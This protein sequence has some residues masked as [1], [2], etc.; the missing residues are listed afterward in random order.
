[1]N[2]FLKRV[3]GLLRRKQLHRDLEDELRFHQE[4][5][6]EDVQGSARKQFGNPTS[7]EEAC[8]DLWAFIWIE[9]LWQDV[10]YAART[11][12]KRPGFTITVVLALALGIGANTTIYTVVRSALAFNI[13]VEHMERLVVITAVDAARRD[14]FS[15]SWTE[16]TDLRR[17][18][19]SIQ[20]LAAYRMVFVNVSDSTGLPERYRGVQMSAN[21]FAVAGAK[22]VMGR[23][24]ISDDERPGETPVVMLSYHIWQNRYGKDPS[25]LGKTI[26]VDEVPRNVIGVM[27]S[28]MQFPADTDLWTPLEPDVRSD[29]ATNLILCGRLASGMKLQSVRAEMDT[30]ARRLE[31]KAPE[32]Y[33]GLIVDVQPFLH[34]IGFYSVRGILIS[35]VFAVGFVLLIACADVANLLLARAAARAREISIRIAIRRRPCADRSAAPCGKCSAIRRRRIARLAHRADRPALVRRRDIQSNAA[36]LDRFFDECPSLRL[37]RRN[38]DR[39][40]YSVRG[41]ARVPA[42][43]SRREQ[44]GQ[45]WRSRSSGWTAR[46]AIGKRARGIRN[47]SLHCAADWGWTHDP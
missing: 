20:A 26:R 14:P 6:T 39:R 25:I 19:K 33:K 12:A 41:C 1:M 13:G 2:R 5:L 40:G 35:V 45:R 46:P 22:P 34:V 18:V 32:S 37:S 31:A 30:I 27:P 4:M 17:E 44:R 28:K 15:H 24:F 21:G 10:R 43:Q 8:R 47:G 11:L 36:L 16:Y 9:T 3:R 23:D 42:G 29:A 38:I 7:L